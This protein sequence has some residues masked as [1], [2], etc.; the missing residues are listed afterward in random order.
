MVEA[1]DLAPPISDFHSPRPA[2]QAGDRGREAQPRPEFPQHPL[3]ILPRA[4]ADG[5]P[6]VLAVDAEQSMVNEEAEETAGRILQHPGDRCGP[7][8]RGHGQ[9]VPLAE[10]AP[11]TVAVQEISQREIVLAGLVEPAPAG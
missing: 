11:E 7:D 8:R 2:P 5:A 3:D 10:P 6:G 4:A 1:A 9:Q